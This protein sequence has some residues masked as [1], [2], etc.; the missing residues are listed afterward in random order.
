MQSYSSNYTSSQI[1]QILKKGSKL[2]NINTN[3]M[4]IINNIKFTGVP[5]AKNIPVITTIKCFKY[6][7]PN[8]MMIVNTET[9]TE[10]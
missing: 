10:E 1:E 2:N 6:D 5:N 9:E 4:M 3:N 7:I 8:N